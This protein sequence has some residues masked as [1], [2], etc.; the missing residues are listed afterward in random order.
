MNNRR[1]FITLV[2]FAGTVFRAACSKEAATTDAT[3]A[4]AA[5][6]APPPAPAMPAPVT[7]AEPTSTGTSTPVSGANLPLL[8]ESD[9]A[10]AGLGYVAVASRADGSKYKNHAAGQACGNCSL[11]AGK[12]GEVGGPCP[13]FAGKQVLA[14]GWCSAYMKKAG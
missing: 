8:E 11:F 14:T 6:P 3:P 4:P 12:A 10:A 2:P 13:L 5:M 1:R 7:P 9:P